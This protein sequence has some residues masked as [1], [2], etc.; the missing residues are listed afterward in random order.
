MDKV[1]TFYGSD[2]GVG[3]TMIAQ[4]CAE[5]LSDEGYKVLLISASRNSGNE[6]LNIEALNDN[7]AG[8]IDDL[9]NNLSNSVLTRE[10]IDSVIVNVKNN[11]DFLQGSKN[12][13]FLRHYRPEHIES[14]ISLLQDDYDLVIIDAGCDPNNPLLIG[15]ILQAKKTFLV[16]T[17]SPKAAQRYK[18]LVNFVYGNFPELA[19]GLIVN[20]FISSPALF[21]ATEISEVYGREIIETISYEADG[22]EVEAAKSTL[23]SHSR[24]F[25]DSI[26]KIANVISE[27]VSPA[28]GSGSSRSWFKRR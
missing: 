26:T 19:P 21:S 25:K 20:R 3:T 23:V 2:H 11:M 1:I 6:F 24:A 13:L 15:A 9:K 7:G 22:R 27:G 12:P 5:I 4:S 18:K 14:L 10:D 28:K 16:T 17:Q 8:G